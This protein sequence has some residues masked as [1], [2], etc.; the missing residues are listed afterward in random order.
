M[1]IQFQQ[2]NY[3]YKSFKSSFQALSNIELTIPAKGEII[4]IC[5]HTG[6]GK[7]TLVQH[8]N[9]LLEAQSGKTII[10]DM[11]LPNK[12]AIKKN[13][14][15][16]RVGLVFQ[17]PEYQLFEETI[18]K[19]IMFG[20]LNMKH[21]VE[22]AKEKAEKAALSVGIAE[23]L[24]QQSPF[25]ISGGQMRRVAIA[26]ILAMEPDIIVL[27][28]PT[29]GLDPQ[30]QKELMDQIY[31]IHQKTK[32]TI[33]II[34]HDM[35]MIA[36]YTNRVIVMKDAKVAFDGSKDALFSNP[37]FPSFSLDFPATLKIMYHLKDTLGIPFKYVYTKEDLLRYLKEVSHV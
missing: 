28:E 36:Q 10:F 31:E 20:P 14:I 26:G 12:K 1:G 17:F 9:G 25:R 33:V 22:V 19:D 27:D 32:K 37:S 35:D 3:A 29:R 18:I 5:G 8:M 34:S 15:R 16:Q 6:S 7:S 4:G 21:S 11:V 24:W 2:V 23:T 30:G 13:H